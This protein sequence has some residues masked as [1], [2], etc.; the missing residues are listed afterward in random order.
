MSV[1]GFV[2]PNDCKTS[3]TDNTKVEFIAKVSVLGSDIG[4]LNP[5]DPNFTFYP[6]LAVG[7]LATLKT[8]LE[9][10]AKTAMQDHGITFGMLDTVVAY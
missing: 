6:V 1:L 5:A 7:V 9:A 4:D 2:L 3:E 10:A 8:N